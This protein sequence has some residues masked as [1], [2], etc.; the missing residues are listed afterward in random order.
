MK[1]SIPLEVDARV[2]P[3]EEREFLLPLAAR[4]CG[5]R[6]EDLVSLE[7]RR[8]SLDARHKPRVKI[9]YS[10]AAEL[11]P[12]VAPRGGGKGVAPLVDAPPY[13]PP[14]NRCNLRQPL[15]VGTGPAGLFG[16]LILAQA[17]ACP[18]IVER[19]RDVARRGKDIRDFFATRRLNPESN[20]LFGEGGAGTWSDGKL[21]TRVRDPRARY[22]LETFVAAGAPPEILYYAHPHL[23]S[24]RLP[25]IIAAIRERIRQ[26]GGRFLWD[27]RVAA[28]EGGPAFQ[29]LRLPDGSRLEGPTALVACGH[30]ARDLIQQMAGQVQTA[31]KGFQVGCR[32]EHPQSFINQT[33]YGMAVP[34]PSLGP[35]EY[36]YSLHEDDQGPGATS[37]CMCPGGEILPATCD[38]QALCT[39]G[40]SNAARDGE[41]A[42]SA[43]ITTLREN[44]FAS[45]REAFAF[46]HHLETRLFT[47]GGGNYCAPAQ[48]ARDFLLGGSSPLPSRTSYRLGLTP[49]RL[50]HLVPNPVRAALRRALAAFDRRAPGFLAEGT[51]EGM[52]TRVSSPVR[53]LRRPD[54]LSTS[55]EGL[56]VAGEGGGMA[57]GIVSAAI[58]GIHLA[59]AMLGNLP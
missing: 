32:I 12:G 3:R 36:L 21:F 17:G 2:V 41:F 44:T 8:R 51:L 55:M 23:G 57:G 16:A 10:L 49:A 33:Q 46:L 50:D 38:P 20:L 48:R 27:T 1:I 53:F 19:G 42:N 34:P 29:A 37:F 9:L 5:L 39:N 28:V 30:S 18:L 58:D 26:L 22:V 4:A 40:M 43:L 54:T 24:D 52:E 59:E 11:R 31:L 14:E 45:P 6:E 13:R 35:A 56:Y 25:A 15:V 7:I 47:L